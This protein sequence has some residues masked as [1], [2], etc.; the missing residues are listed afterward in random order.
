VQ[1]ERKVVTVLFADLVGFT[2]R[3]ESLDPED[4]EAILRPYHERLRS[5]LERHGGTVEKFIGD[6]VMALFGAPSAHEDDP[7]RAVRAALAIRDW[8]RDEGDL[9]VRIGIT[10]GEALVSLEARPQAGEG[11]ASGD[12]VNTAARLQ[13]G[14]QANGILVDE[15][16]YRATE[17]S[18]E[19]GESEPVE[20]KG[21]A[22][23]V[24]VWE[25]LQARSRLEVDVRRPRTALVGRTRE[26]DVLED[27]LARVREERAPQLVT[28]VGEPGIG[29][30]RLVYELF[31]SLEAEPELVYWRQG[32]SLP[33][34]EGVSFWSLGEI[35]KA[36]AG[37]LE[38]DTSEAVEEKLRAAVGSM[39]DPE[40]LVRHLGPLVGVG[41]EI[42]LGPER[43]EAF[44]A[45]RHFFEELADERPL[46][47]VFED[48]HW[49]DEGVLD[50][51]DHLVDWAT[52]VPILV[53]ATA[54]PELLDRRPGWGGGKRNATTVSLSPLSDED[55]AAMVA[56]LEASLPAEVQ[57]AVLRRAGGNPLYAEE[58]ARML[59][60]R[61]AAEELPENIQGV[62]AARLDGLPSEEKALLQRAAVLGKVFWL[63]AVEAMDGASGRE[64]E[65][66]LH[67]LE[68]KEFIR[69]ERR[70]S[71]EGDTEFAFLH[72]LVRDVAYGQ[73]P[74]ADRA[75]QHR[76]AADWIASLG[77][78]EDHA[79]ML[80]HHYLQAL[81][82]AEAAGMDTAT[83][84]E[85]ARRALSD[86]GDRAA[87]LYAVEAAERFYDAALRLYD[88]GEPERAR[89]L[90]R[91]A[92][93]S[94]PNIV[95]GDP[96]RLVQAVDALRAAGDTARAA[97]GEMLLS[98]VF[99]YQ[100]L[101]E[102]VQEHADR[103]FEL[104]GDLPPSRS[105][106]W[107]RARLASRDLVVGDLARAMELGLQ[108]QSEAAALGWDEGVS[109]ARSTIGMAL[110]HQGH[111]R[112][113]VAEVQ[114]AIELAAKVGSI[115]VVSRGYNNLSV[116]QLM[117]G[118]VEASY[119]AR[120]E[121][122]R[123]DRQQG[124][125]FQ[126][127]WYDTTLSDLHYRRGDWTEAFELA[128]R[129]I[130]PIEGGSPHYSGPQAYLIR[131]LIRLAR[132]DADG[133]IADAEKA[134]AL[135]GEAAE[136]QQLSFVLPTSAYVFALADDSDRA[137]ASLR[138]FMR[139][140][141]SGPTMGFA[142]N[143]LP[144]AAIAALRFG[145]EG[146]LMAALKAHPETP[147]TAVAR[148][149]AS[150]DFAGAAEVLHGT[151]SKPDE[152]EARLHAGTD[153]Q[154][155]QALEF[156]RSVGASRFIAEGEALLAASA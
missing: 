120:R 33:Y 121:A 132:D 148:M 17:R 70:S 39:E 44:G 81:Q 15:T 28:L 146:E 91:R 64:L 101:L 38:T 141:Q 108:A 150:G 145:L 32:R 111:Y 47:L 6:A 109:D 69:R 52:T 13:A 7:E 110:V 30:S 105:T 77:R 112:E 48:L 24:A 106:A 62:I 131:A 103:A 124:S 85:P 9:E 83:L 59:A 97:E 136:L 12:I 125:S 115:R 78:A 139:V 126:A 23:P 21:K 118:D 123:S 142:A 144:V 86:A 49:A 26:V 25:P 68:R 57:A 100:G 63:G 1:R 80:A 96:E 60:E 58:F 104:L 76:R 67:A 87:A 153:D 122:E 66:R 10:T 2:S 36:Q 31:N 65:E 41:G 152:A 42:E 89:L 151:G 82:L 61:G 149:Y 130:G 16:T 99:W 134:L 51:V 98:L 8:A 147:W 92:V 3:A 34:G 90:L 156:Y 74:R 40:W 43:E 137:V 127:H 11:M 22:Q 37:I 73:I 27:A 128:E 53:V 19:Y 72:V 117:G 140:L 154:L 129:A 20:A 114:Q 155:Q 56:S 113:G 143:T 71:V 133:A 93:P 55:T 135:V 79:E 35:V 138:E 95:S 54:R 29:K 5:E 102:P 116:A 46:V 4:V 119:K 50:F 88:E 107:V 45:W 94:I 84:V 14:A 75:D 18:I